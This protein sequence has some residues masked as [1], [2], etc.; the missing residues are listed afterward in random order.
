MKEEHGARE[1]E[2]RQRK[3]FLFSFRVSRN[4]DLAKESVF[5][6]IFANGKITLYRADKLAEHKTLR[7]ML[8]EDE[9]RLSNFPDF[10]V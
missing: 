3:L 8:L 4:Y 2:G 6:C 9:T 10:H 1:G 5:F 7:K